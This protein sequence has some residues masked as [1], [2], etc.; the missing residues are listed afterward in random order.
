MR[1]VLF[2]GELER[3]HVRA[4]R[5]PAH[6]R[7]GANA[8]PLA[9]REDVK[10]D[11][12]QRVEPEAET[13]GE[14]LGGGAVPVRKQWGNER[15]E[16]TRDLF[17]GRDGL[18]AI[19]I[20]WQVRA[21]LLHDADGDEERR[22]GIECGEGGAREFAQPER[23]HGAANTRQAFKSIVGLGL[24]V[25]KLDAIVASVGA[26][27]LLIAV[28]GAAVNGGGLARGPFDVAFPTHEHSLMLPAK[29]PI[30]A[31]D[32]T[33]FTLNESNLVKV[34]ATVHFASSAPFPPTASAH[35]RLVGP[36]GA[37][38]EVDGGPAPGAAAFDVKLDVPLAAAPSATRL[39]GADPAAA[40]RAAWAQNS[41][42]GQG[43][44]SLEI[45]FDAGS[46][47]PNAT[48]GQSVQASY[49]WTAWIPKAD[50]VTAPGP[51]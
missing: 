45:S 16:S 31:R 42:V 34:N 25:Q 2:G 43:A 10:R 3:A 32:S 9:I 40:E 37:T 23:R 50:P 51:R 35:V 4:P 39:A 17:A 8:V 24:A 28:A 1:D 22:L 27:I 12:A 26:A 7:D 14:I 15:I 18:D 47:L 6:E 48:P 5:V 41:T 20:K 33:P 44:W 49:G 21:V 46:P 19:S 30:P 36:N 29:S 38:K 11:H 13:A